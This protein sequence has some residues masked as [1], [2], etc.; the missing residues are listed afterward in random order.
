[1]RELPTG[2]VTFVFTDVEG[3]T[4]LLRRVGD[5]AYAELLAEHARLVD[6][7]LAE[8]DGVVVDTQGDAFFAAF[9]VAT[10]AVRAAARAAARARPDASSACGSASTPASP[11]LTSTGY[12]GL[13]VPRA[14]RICAAG[15]GGQVLLSQATRELV[16]DELPEGVAVR[17][18][19]EHRL[20]DLTRPQR[21]SQ[22]VIDGLPH[23]FPPLR[24]LENRPTN[25]PVQPTPLI[26]RERGARAGRRAAAP[27]RRPPVDADRPGRLGQDAPRAPGRRGARRG[28]PAR[29]LPRRARADHRPRAAPA[30]DR[31]DA[32]ARARAKPLERHAL[33]QKR[34][35]LV[36]DNVEHLLEAAPDA[37]RDPRRRAAA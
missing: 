25:L 5:A 37:Q 27:R 12:V 20:K 7:A 3:S 36:L 28:L 24:T 33:A 21:L 22:L 15:H 8:A 11:A 30:D 14:A 26:G 16:E 13:D 31:A 10:G 1:M 35:L 17:D 29:R 4:E 9:P 34:L 2:T 6:D 32:S 19:G 23:E 18:L